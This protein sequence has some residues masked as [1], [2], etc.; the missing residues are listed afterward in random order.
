MQFKEFAGEILVRG[1]GAAVVVVQVVE[2]GGRACDLSEK[3]AEIAERVSA[4]HGVP[5]GK[6][7]GDVFV[8]VGVDV[9]MVVP[10]LGH[11]LAHLGAGMDG[12]DEGGGDDL[13]RR[14]DAFGPGE[15]AGPVDQRHEGGRIGGEGGE[16][17]GFVYGGPAAEHAVVTGFVSDA[18]AE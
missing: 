1:G 15:G 12:A 6:G 3:G 7:D 9:E 17:A 5:G 4:E 8:L 14:A 11:H 16:R 2:H 13:F 18:E 10:E